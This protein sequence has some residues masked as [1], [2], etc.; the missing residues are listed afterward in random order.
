MS[1]SSNKK[2][3]GNLLEKELSEKLHSAHV[4]FLIS[5]L[6]LRN[7]ECGQV[8]VS[9]LKND[10]IYLIEAKNGGEINHK[11]Y[12]RLKKSGELVSKIL[13]KSV[14]IKLSFAK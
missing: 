2:E 7:Y 5:S 8:D 11:Q 13:D 6:V 9:Y 1:N 10:C 14:F 12:F 4:P 3:K